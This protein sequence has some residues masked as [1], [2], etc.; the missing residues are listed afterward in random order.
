MKKVLASVVLAL[1]G[2]VALANMASACWFFWY[3]PTLPQK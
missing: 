1:L 2:V 3:Q